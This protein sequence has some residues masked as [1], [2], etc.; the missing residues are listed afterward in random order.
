MFPKE[1]DNLAVRP[2]NFCKTQ[3]KHS[4]CVCLPL[5]TLNLLAFKAYTSP[6]GRNPGF[7]TSP[8]LPTGADTTNYQ[9]NIHSPTF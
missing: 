7:L 4:L 9:L 6:L 8:S 5:L 3:R 2:Y 1:W